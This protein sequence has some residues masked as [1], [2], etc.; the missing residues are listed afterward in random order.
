VASAVASVV[1][2]V[3]SAASPA[4]S[5]VSVASPALLPAR[6]STV[7]AS[8]ARSVATAMAIKREWLN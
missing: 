7:V 2:S 4:P 3:A 1:A 5:V 6:A 8:D